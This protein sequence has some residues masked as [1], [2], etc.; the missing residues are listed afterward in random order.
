VTGSNGF[1][2]ETTPL[3]IEPHRGKV[4]EDRLK[5][6]SGNKAGNIFQEDE[7]TSHFADCAGQCGPEPS[8]VLGPFLIAR[9]APRLAREPCSE[10]IHHASK[11]SEVDAGHIAAPNRR[12]LQALFFHACQEAGR[13]SAI[14]LNV[15]HS[16]G[17]DAEEFEGEGGSFVEHADA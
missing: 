10:H 3:S 13:S 14:P 11:L 4:S 2:T 6:S 8:L 1:C 17:S 5:A 16:A 9:V 7:P 12:G 15:T